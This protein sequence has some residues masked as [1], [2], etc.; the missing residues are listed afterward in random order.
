MAEKDLPDLSVFLSDYINDS[1]EDLQTA[2]RALL[3]LEKDPGE[4]ERLNEIFRAVHTLKSSS[5]LLEFGSIAELAHFTEDLLDRL[6]RQELALN[7]NAIDLLL[8]I[9]DAL[10]F[11]IQRRVGGEGEKEQAA[12]AAALTEDLKRKVTALESQEMLVRQGVIIIDETGLI[13]AFNPAAERIFGWPAAEVVGR[14]VSLLMPEPY[15]TEQDAYLANYLRTG[16]AKV[17]GVGREV[18]GL[19]QDGSTFPLEL[20]VDDVSLGGRRRFI[21]IVRKIAKRKGRAASTVALEK[22]ETIRVHVKLLDALF[23]LVG[24]L[25][26]TKNR[27]DT[28]VAASAQKDLKAALGTMERLVNEVQENVSAA[29]LV[30]VDEIFQKF[31][32]MVRDLAVEQ[33]KEIDFVLEGRQIELDKSALDAIGEPLVHLLR[34]AVDHGIEPPEV[35]HASHKS[36]RGTVRLAAKREENHT[37]IEVEDDGAG[38]HVAWVKEIAVR[39]GILSDAEVQALPDKDALNLIFAPGFSSAREVTGLSG[40]GVGLD[41]VK[42]CAERLGG[43]VAVA[44]RPGEGTRFMLQLPVATAILQTLMV[45]VGEHIFA[46]PSDIVLET[47][48]V[49]PG[50]VR[51]VGKQLALIIRGEAIPFINLTDLLNLPVQGNEQDQIAVVVHR[52]DKLIGL[53]VDMLLDQ[54]EN[55]IKPFD[56]VAQK[57]RGFSGGTILGDGRVALLLD[58]PALI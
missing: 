23:N 14:K 29:R 25:V 53:G 15:K 44:T 55:I 36:K 30:A 43:S 17:I 47:V 19:H 51:G 56:P 20:A 50:D 34:N 4:K 49:K 57:L 6:R 22:S 38:I 39:K 1:R 40:R 48:D 2:N 11:L 46:I 9:V 12:T 37:I 16:K 21:G 27:I 13:E 32:R 10:E 54:M 33:H 24:E 52:E 7:Q 35:R 5:A 58:I 18:V 3:A 28:I 45:G 8:E 26:I 42:T 41:V 31:P